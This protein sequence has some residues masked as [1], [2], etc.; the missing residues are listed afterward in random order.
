MDSDLHI[1]LV[2]SNNSTF[3]NVKVLLKVNSILLEESGSLT[4]TSSLLIKFAKPACAVSQKELKQ[5]KLANLEMTLS[6]V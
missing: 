1:V 3:Y 5:S 6:A 4:E 2:E